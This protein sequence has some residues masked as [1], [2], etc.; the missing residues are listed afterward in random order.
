MNYLLG[1]FLA[2]YAG[3]CTGCQRITL[4]SDSYGDITLTKLP[5]S[6]SLPGALGRSSYASTPTDSHGAHY[7]YFSVVDIDSG[8]GRWILND[9]LGVT[10][11]ATAFVG[12]S[13][14]IYRPVTALP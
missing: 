11:H 7:L 9:E 12:K 8:T 2:V 6:S 1:L 3:S 10:N 5:I 13:R 14:T 4:E